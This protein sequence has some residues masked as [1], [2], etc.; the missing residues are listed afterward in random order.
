MATKYILAFVCLSLAPT[1]MG[2]TYQTSLVRTD[3]VNNL[4]A[5]F[6][7]RSQLVSSAN[8]AEVDK[9]NLIMNASFSFRG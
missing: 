6:S 7:S 1:C 3:T 4:C 2:I 9:Y 5:S 8:A